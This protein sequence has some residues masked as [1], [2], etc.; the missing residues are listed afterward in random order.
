M[1][2]IEGDVVVKKCLDCDF[3]LTRIGVLN[4]C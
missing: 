1:S 3:K 2:E 4:V